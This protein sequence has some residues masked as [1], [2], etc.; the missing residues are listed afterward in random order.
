M[1]IFNI[2]F[3]HEECFLSQYRLQ[4]RR[5]RQTN[6]ETTQGIRETHRGP[7]GPQK[8]G[9]TAGAYLVRRMTRSEGHSSG[10]VLNVLDD[11]A[12]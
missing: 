11:P 5:D 9:K 6:R 10:L 8:K 7:P 12:E 3:W 1:F 4:D 2:L